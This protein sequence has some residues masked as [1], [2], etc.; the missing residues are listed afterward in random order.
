MYAGSTIQFC[1]LLTP[2]AVLSRRTERERSSGWSA[3]TTNSNWSNRL[4]TITR[5]RR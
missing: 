2:C 4:R 1:G 5:C 3:W